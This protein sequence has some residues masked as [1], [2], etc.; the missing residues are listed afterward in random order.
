MDILKNFLDSVF[1]AYPESEEVARARNELYSMME[2]RFSELK[3]DG[4]SDEEAAGI[5]MK[6]FGDPAEL[7]EAL[8]M[9]NTPVLYDGNSNERINHG[10]DGS[11]KS[12]LGRLI[13]AFSTN[14]DKDDV[15]KSWRFSAA[16]GIKIDIACTDIVI[17]ARDDISDINVYFTGHKKLMPNVKIDKDVLK[18][19]YDKDEH[20]NNMPKG[21]LTIDIPATMGFAKKSSVE[22]GLGSLKMTGLNFAKLKVDLALGSFDM[23]SCNIDSAKMDLAMGDFTMRETPWVSDAELDIDCSFGSIFM[24]GKKLGKKC[25]DKGKNDH[26]IKA[27]IAMGKCRLLTE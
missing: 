16:A 7:R 14:N 21:N 23:Y 19:K 1:A 26:S 11:H 10:F 25:K 24:D 17:E 22:S 4:H 15:N 9:P 2:D 13:D 3:R 6:E 5:V 18:I 8:G 27:E 12:F 20:F